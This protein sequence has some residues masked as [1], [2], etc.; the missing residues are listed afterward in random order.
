MLKR[1]DNTASFRNI[2]QTATYY[3]KV[4]NLLYTSDIKSEFLNLFKFDRQE[5]HLS[6]Q[7]LKELNISVD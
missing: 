5:I 4:S 6:D 7:I 3:A 1:V 2:V